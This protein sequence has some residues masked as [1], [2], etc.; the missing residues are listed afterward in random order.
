MFAALAGVPGT[1]ILMVALSAVA[2]WNYMA[3]ADGPQ[4]VMKAINNDMIATSLRDI[5]HIHHRIYTSNPLREPETLFD[6]LGLDPSKPP[7]LGDAWHTVGEAEQGEAFKLISRQWS[8]R[9]MKLMGS[10]TGPGSERERQVDQAAAALSNSR[11]A[12]TYMKAV[13]PR[14]VHE[15]GDRRLEAL[16]DVC[17]DAWG[18]PPGFEEQHED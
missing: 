8:K 1:G 14:I 3:P 9:K 16:Q 2:Y 13:M 12:S 18:V 6:V 11:L 10:E 7:F 5:C 15:R 4:P 17:K